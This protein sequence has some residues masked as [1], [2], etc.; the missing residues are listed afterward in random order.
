MIDENVNRFVI[1]TLCEANVNFVDIFTIFITF[2]NEECRVID[3]FL[4]A[5]SHVEIE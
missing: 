1:E 4:Q 5:K 3:F 2:T